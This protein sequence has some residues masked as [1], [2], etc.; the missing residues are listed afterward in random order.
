MLLNYLEFMQKMEQRMQFNQK[1]K[2]VLQAYSDWGHEIAP[3]MAEQFYNYLEHDS[4]MKSVLY[5]TETRI[6]SLKETF[7]QWFH[8]MFTGLDNW[9]NVY[10]ERR[11][12]IGLIHVRIGIG[13]KYMVPAMAT[14][15]CEVQKRQKLEDI[16]EF[17]T[18]ALNKICMIDLAFIEQAYVEVLSNAVMK[19][20]GWTEV[21]FRRMISAGVNSM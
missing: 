13:P 1:D 5:S 19:E 11:W 7:I 21:L 3:A 9:G 10:A 2:A 14:V 16:D 15:V 6:H 4:E 20:T 18:Q 12:R 8:E 17:L